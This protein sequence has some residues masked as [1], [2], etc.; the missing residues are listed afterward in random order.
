VGVRPSTTAA[1]VGADTLVVDQV[2]VTFVGLTALDSVSLSVSPGEAVGLIGPNGAGKTTLF[3]VICGFTKPHSG[4]VSVGGRELTGHRPHDLAP[5]GIARTLQGVGLWRGLSVV[6]NVMAGAQPRVRSGLLAAVLG[7]PRSSREERTLRDQALEELDRLGIEGHAA[8][9]PS[10]LPY[11]VQK[12]V[13][14][15]RALMARPRLLLLDEPASGLSEHEI[16]ELSQLLG[17]LRAR[18]GVLVVEHNMDFVMGLCD[19]L[20]VLN[21]GQVIADGRPDEVRD[22]PEV[23]TAYLGER[24]GVGEGAADD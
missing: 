7:L 3:N 12:R 16:G 19:R 1:A 23:V 8:A 22:D 5:L 4:H 20:V 9:W 2:T 6:E 18:M 15:A 11:A 21:F 24:V 17:E 13:A 10:T 14:L